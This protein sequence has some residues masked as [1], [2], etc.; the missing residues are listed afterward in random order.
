MKPLPVLVLVVV[1]LAVGV[2]LGATLFAARAP[3]LGPD[4]SEREIR[5]LTEEN[6]RLAGVAKEREGGAASVAHSGGLEDDEAVVV[7][8]AALAVP[9]GPTAGAPAAAEADAAPVWFADWKDGALREVDFRALGESVTRINPLVV[10]ITEAAKRGERP[11]GPTLAAIQRESGSLLTAA[12]KI[13]ERIGGT[14]DANEYFSDP[15]VMANAMATTLAAAGQP[16]VTAQASGL[17]Q[18]GR[19]FT[20]ELDRLRET[21]DESTLKLTR[22]AESATLK[23]RFFEEAFGLLTPEQVE[24]LNPSVTRDRIRLTVFSSAHLYSLRTRVI[25]FTRE[26]EI[27]APL[28]GGV[29]Y[30]LRLTEAERAR[31]KPVYDA[32]FAELP[33]ELLDEEADA[34]DLLGHVKAQRITAWAARE[35]D[36]LTRILAEVP[37]EGDRLVRA[38][39]LGVVGVPIRKPE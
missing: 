19:Y 12:V 6:A 20:D 35:A 24:I 30:E 13:H 22:L 14:D 11:S 39:S 32:W 8:A 9:D 31:A 1:V 18:M 37:L 33:R 4:G 15:A 38:R 25:P 2:G 36:L 27:E 16:L 34:L 17:E 21:W 7:G 29:A 23:D 28:F 10:E 5:R 26:S 3:G